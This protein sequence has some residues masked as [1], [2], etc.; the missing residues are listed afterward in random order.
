[1][2]EAVLNKLFYLQT[3]GGARNNPG[4]AGIAY[5][6]RDGQGEILEKEGRFIG[7][8]TNNVAEYTALLEGLKALAKHQPEKVICLLDSELVV[9]QLQGLYRVKQP[10]LQTLFLAVK[11]A[12]AVFPKVEYRAAPREKNKEADKLVNKAIDAATR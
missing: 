12:A 6:I 1:M 8:A 4:P 5:I 2:A 10:H 11:K 3:D 7:L 9:R